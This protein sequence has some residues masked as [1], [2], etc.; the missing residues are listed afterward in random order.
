LATAIT[1]SAEVSMSNDPTTL[2]TREDC[3]NK[4]K[5]FA[6]LKMNYGP[7]RKWTEAEFK[8]SAPA[9]AWLDSV[10][11][12]FDVHG[13]PVPGNNEVLSVFI[14]GIEISSG[15]KKSSAVGSIKNH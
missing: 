9:Q 10:R 5:V 12:P 1:R 2:H 6:R 15:N 13:T 8:F 14:D 3:K 4:A 11:P 7:Q